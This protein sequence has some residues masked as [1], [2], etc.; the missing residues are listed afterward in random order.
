MIPNLTLLLMA[1]AAGPA[2]AQD[3]LAD[4]LRKAIVEEESNQNL[5]RA[6]QAYESILRQF[7]EERLTVATALFHLAECYR[8]LGDNDR[9]AAAY[10]RV[11][12]DFPDQTRLADASRKYL[13]KD[14]GAGQDAQGIDYRKK[15][16]EARRRYRVVLE[17]E[18]KLVETQIEVMQRRVEIG[19]VSSVGPEMTA[20]KK[21]HLELQRTLAAF[22]A[23]ATPIPTIVVK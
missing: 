9:A 22:D 23:G 19:L 12:R 20:L 16:D 15:Y 13:P 10:R 7:D 5:D 3:K 2:F 14:L 21:E 17:Q 8:K 1:L 11:V 4:Q 18:I 6:V